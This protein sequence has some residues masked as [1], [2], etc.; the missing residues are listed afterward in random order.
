[1]KKYESYEDY[2]E[3]FEDYDFDFGDDGVDN[4]VSQCR[5]DVNPS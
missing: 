4:N 1:M 3:D 5:I 2:E